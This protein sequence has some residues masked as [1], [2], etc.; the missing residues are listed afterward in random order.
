MSNRHQ[1][2][3]TRKGDQLIFILQKILL[4]STDHTKQTRTRLPSIA[5]LFARF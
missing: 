5:S 4:L 2:K 1:I 3:G